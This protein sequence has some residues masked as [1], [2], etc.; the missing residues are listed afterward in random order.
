MKIVTV[1]GARPQFVKAG[2]LSRVFRRLPQV[3]EHIVH[4]GQHYDANMSDVFFDELDIASPYLN[5]GIGSG[6]QGQQT[7]RM[8]EAIER[9][10]VEL[11][12]HWLLVY[13]DTNSTLAAALAAAKLHIPVAHVEA[14]LRSFNR[15]MPEE[16]N[17]VL[18]DHI[19]SRL[20]APTI[21]AVTHLQREGIDPTKIVLAGDVMFDAYQHYAN[22]SPP[23]GKITSPPPYLLVTIHRA[24][25]TDNELRMLAIWNALLMVSREHR[26][27]FPMHPRTRQVAQRMGLLDLPRDTDRFTVIDPVGYR[28]MI[29]L[30]KGAQAIITDSGGVQKEAYFCAVPCVTLRTETEWVELVDLGWNHLASPDS[31]SEMIAAIHQAAQPGSLS[32]RPDGLYGGGQAAELIAQDLLAM[33]Q[34]AKQVHN[35]VL[36]QSADNLG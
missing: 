12:P 6:P 8:L 32:V 3:C 10:L 4:T 17:R 22:Q 35:H 2:A 24:E 16:I 31:Q 5:L 14:G 23:G 18:T 21:Q 7:G 20:Y 25:N 29:S 11:H 13:G 33:T 1:V 9:V 30:Q 34:S 36:K 15:E 28:E 26:V 27:V 19:A